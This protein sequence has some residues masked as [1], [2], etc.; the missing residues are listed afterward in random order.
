MLQT[1]ARSSGAKAHTVCGRRTKQQLSH[2]SEWRSPGG[3]GCGWRGRLAP[4]AFYRITTLPK[5]PQLPKMPKFEGG[6]SVIS[7][8]RKNKETLTA[9]GLTETRRNV[10]RQRRQAG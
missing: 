10:F 7:S 5:L 3:S 1:S 4:K 2:R 9:F 6:M 8:T